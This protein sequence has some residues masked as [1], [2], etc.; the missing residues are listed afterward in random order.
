[1]GGVV[2]MGQGVGN[3]W[4]TYLGSCFSTCRRP[5]ARPGGATRPDGRAGASTHSAET[6]VPR[7]RAPLTARH[8]G[9]LGG[10]RVVRAQ[11]ADQSVGAVRRPQREREGPSFP[12]LS[13]VIGPV[14]PGLKTWFWTEP[15]VPGALNRLSPQSLSVPGFGWGL[16][17]Q[18]QSQSL[19]LEPVPSPS[20]DCLWLGSL[21]L[22]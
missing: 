2:S 5:P 21:A 4:D 8:R 19:G 15:P 9:L 17:P 16:S 18:S 14:R 20:R 1:M 22:P 7:S 10:M 6:R 13:C 12:R 11:A 3:G